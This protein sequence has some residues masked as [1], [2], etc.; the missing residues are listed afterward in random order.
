MFL[1]F[2][3]CSGDGL[4]TSERGF[5]EEKIAY[6][7][8]LDRYDYDKVISS[9]PNIILGFLAKIIQAIAWFLNTIFGYI[10]IAALV[11]L[12]IYILFRYVNKERTAYTESNE[13]LRLIEESALD[14]IDFSKLINIA[15]AKK[16]YRL[17]V[18]FTFLKSL[19]RLSLSKLIIIKEGK[20]NY[21]YYYELPNSLQPAYRQVLS[22]FEYVWYGEFESSLAIYNRITSNAEELQELID[23]ADV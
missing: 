23:N 15:L 21:E 22:V 9:E 18:R 16:D 17:A 1:V 8:N 2:I 6:Y 3:S 19:K 4:I 5:S 11:G 20:T 13:N 7:N 12:L 14:D 10:M